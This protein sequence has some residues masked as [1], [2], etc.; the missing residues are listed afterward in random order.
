MWLLDRCSVNKLSFNYEEFRP[1]V[2]L[3]AI[4]KLAS[5]V[6]HIIFLCNFECGYRQYLHITNIKKCG[7]IS[8]CM[9]N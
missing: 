9:L 4:L 1:I 5:D 2:F 6:E 3:V 7:A 8:N